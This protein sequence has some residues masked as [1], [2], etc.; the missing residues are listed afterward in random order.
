[1]SELG[2]YGIGRVWFDAFEPAFAGHVAAVGDV[3]VAVGVVTAL[4][5]GVMCVAQ[6]HMKRMLAFATISFVGTFLI[7][8]GTLGEDGVAGAAMFIVADGLTKAALFG[9]VGILQHRKGEVYASRLRGAGRDIGMVAVPFALGALGFAALPGFG[10]FEAKALIEDALTATGR[11][12]AI[13]ALVLGPMLSCAAVLKLTAVVF[14]GWGGGPAEEGTGDGDDD[15]ERAVEDHVSWA[16][17]VPTALLI[18][19]S[20]AIGVIPGAAE[21]F[22]RAAHA[23]TDG[24]AYRGAILQGAETALAPVPGFAAK[25]TAFLLSALTLAGAVAI[26]AISLRAREGSGAARFGARAIAPLKAVHSGH[27]GDYVAWVVLGIAAFG[28]AFALAAA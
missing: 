20:I 27:V 21:A 16:L 4:V 14:L 15:P 6:D 11:E 7:G 9:A 1:M 12:W 25:P 8:L 18:A 26:A 28:G 23:F 24:G 10:A 17:S 22:L 5:G 19:G 13:P 3:L 2:I